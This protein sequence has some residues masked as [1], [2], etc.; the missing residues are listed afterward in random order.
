MAIQRNSAYSTANFLNISTASDPGNVR[1][2][3]L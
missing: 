2:A 1:L 3:S